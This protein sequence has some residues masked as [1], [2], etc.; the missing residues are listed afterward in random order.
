MEIEKIK[1]ILLATACFFMACLNLWNEFKDWFDRKYQ[2]RKGQGTNE[3]APSPTK[4]PVPDIVG[5]RSSS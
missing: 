2:L 1:A 5:K 3:K 4:E